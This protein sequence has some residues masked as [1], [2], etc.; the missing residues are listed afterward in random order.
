MSPLDMNSNT[1]GGKEVSELVMP[2]NYV[3]MDQAELEYDGG[4]SLTNVLKIVGIC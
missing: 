1:K 3:D 2:S 4:A